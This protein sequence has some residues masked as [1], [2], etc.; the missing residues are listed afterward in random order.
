MRIPGQGQSSTATLALHPARPPDQLRSQRPGSFAQLGSGSSRAPRLANGVLK[1]PAFTL[2][3]VSQEPEDFEKVRFS[4][5][6]GA[7]EKRAVRRSSTS[8]ELKLRQFFKTSFVTIIICSFSFRLAP[9]NVTRAP[10][11]LKDLGPTYNTDFERRNC[12]NRVKSVHSDRNPEPLFRNPADTPGPFTDPT[13]ETTVFQAFS[14]A[15][16]SRHHPRCYHSGPLS[17]ISHWTSK[18]AVSRRAQARWPSVGPALRNYC[19]AR[20]F[21]NRRLSRLGSLRYEFVRRPWEARRL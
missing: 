9:R 19:Y 10:S 16:P 5:C 7:N 18:S 1:S 8:T 2:G 4:G 12:V 6:I 14:S 3:D 11:K 20:R 21:G 17:R 13:G 15:P